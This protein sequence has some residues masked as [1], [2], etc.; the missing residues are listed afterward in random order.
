MK[1]KLLTA[2]LALVMVFAG[3]LGITTAMAEEKEATVV[4][5]NFTNY[6]GFAG[7]CIAV[8][9]GAP[10]GASDWYNWLPALEDYVSLVNKDGVAYDITWLDSQGNYF[11]VN[12]A[13]GYTAAVG[14]RLTLKAG[15]AVNCG[16]LFEDVTYEYST[17]G[18]PFTLY[19]G[20][21]APVTP[22]EP[23]TPEEPVE[24]N[25]VLEINQV[26]GSY[27]VNS[28]FVNWSFPTTVIVRFET[29]NWG[30]DLGLYAAILDYNVEYVEFIDHAGN[31]AA[32]NDITYVQQGHFIFRTNTV[33][34]A[35]A[36]FVLK[37]GFSVKID[38][39]T[40]KLGE[41]L[42]FLFTKTEGEQLFLFDE[43]KVPT[44]IE[45]T[46]TDA[47]KDVAVDATLQLGWTLSAGSVG[48]PVF[49]VSDETVASVNENG[50][51][52][53]LKEGTATV[54]A[55]VGGVSD[56]FDINVVPALTIT[57]VEIVNNYTYYVIKGEEAVLPTLRAVAVYEGGSKGSEFVLVE[58]EN[59]T[60][61]A[62]TTEEIGTQ[63]LDFVVRYKGVDY[64]VG[65]T[66]EVYEPYDMVI[67][68]VAIVEWFA[69]A[70]FVQYPDTSANVGNITDGAMVSNVIDKITYKKA[71]GTVVNGGFYVLGG[72]NIALFY[73][74]G[75]DINNYNEYYEAGDVITLEAGLC[76]WRWTGELMATEADNGALKPDTGMC[77]VECVLR[78]TVQYRYD[79]NVWGF[80]LEYEDFTVAEAEK[81]LGIGEV[82]SVGA[83]RVPANATSG[84]ITYTSSDESVATV[85]AR[86]VINAI[87]EGTATITATING[88]TAGEIVKTVT[89]NVVDEVVGIKFGV[90]SLSFYVGDE[91][92]VTTLT[93]TLEYAS[94]KTGEAV[95]LNGATVAG[96][97]LTAVNDGTM[98]IS[99]TVDGT[100]YTGAIAYSVTEKPATKGCVSSVGAVSAMAFVMLGCAA[101]LKRKH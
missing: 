29:S 65:Y 34:R 28:D 10:V 59:L 95:D 60:V 62:F 8:N 17:A 20:T 9:F 39:V 76:G 25:V 36:K 46:N 92:D 1:K 61:P 33:M 66:V 23:T 22:D 54:T 13:Q 77:I 98:V 3:A 83:S 18:Q 87:A 72:G 100:T 70:I 42:V 74:N 14:D 82:A 99:V 11:L 91:F 55:T 16:K 78:E 86:G 2:L 53:G 89:V 35:G 67:K 64:T 4:D 52:T 79:G 48:T 51:V 58:G 12:R 5:V 38:N 97:D 68:E 7:D 44:S 73:Y 80:Y 57:G 41:D 84:E 37:Q 69:F 93:A 49:T 21:D 15:F 31:K 30:G 32:L 50:V 63:Q 40:A 101:I 43:A 26:N 19:E 85:S 56:T 71:D 27:N 6:A 90:E 94:G 88:G 81:T 47:D 24:S 75:L 96:L 45:I